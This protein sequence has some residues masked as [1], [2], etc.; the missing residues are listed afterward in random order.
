MFH[1]IQTCQIPQ[2]VTYQ[3]CASSTQ[4][5]TLYMLI[6]HELYLLS[7]ADS[8]LIQLLLLMIAQ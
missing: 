8:T 7:T 6:A 5:F 3:V 2:N 1:N 4:Y